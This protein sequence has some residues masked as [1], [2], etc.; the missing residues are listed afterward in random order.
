LFLIAPRSQ[1]R[2]DARVRLR[3]PVERRRARNRAKARAENRRAR[4]VGRRVA[5]RQRALARRVAARKR[6]VA[7]NRRLRR[8][9]IEVCFRSNGRTVCRVPRKLVCFTREADDRTV[10]RARKP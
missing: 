8:E 3:D 5:R 10:C 7:R 6:R 9:H 2:R 4:I 1:A